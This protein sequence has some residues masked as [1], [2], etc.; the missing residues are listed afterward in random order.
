MSEI[1]RIPYIR[2]RLDSW[3]VWIRTGTT[4]AGTSVLGR[5]ADAA[6]G[7]KFSSRV[8]VN[9]LECSLTDQAVSALPPEYKDA[10][11]GWHTSDGTLEDVARHLG[12]VKRTLQRRLARADAMLAEWFNDRKERARRA[13]VTT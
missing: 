2:E 5:L 9:E 7:V 8:P 6:N 1:Q 12:I 3:A 10:V 11:K 13:R 4:G